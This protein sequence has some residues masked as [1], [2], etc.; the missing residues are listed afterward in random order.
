MK[1][2]SRLVLF[3]LPM[4]SAAL[5][6]PPKAPSLPP[7]AQ[8]NGSDPSAISGCAAA[9]GGGPTPFGCAVTRN[10]QVMRADPG[11]PPAEVTPPEGELATQGYDR[12]RAGKAP[13]LQ[14]IPNDA[15]PD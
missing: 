10:L 8:A 14:P 9:D 11:P 15:A 5:A 4:A 7:L 13:E 12:L 3:A 6:W 2:L 1:A